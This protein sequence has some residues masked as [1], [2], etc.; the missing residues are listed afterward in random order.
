M[1]T[2]K[3]VLIIADVL[4]LALC[5]VQC[6]LSSKD[7]TKYF[8]LKDT[9]DMIVI[10]A[11]EADEITVVLEDGK[12]ILADD[13]FPANEDEIEG[14]LNAVES[15]RVLDKVGS[16]NN[17]A[18]LD[19]YEL[20]DLKKTTVTFSKDGKVIRTLNLGKEAVSDSQSYITVDNGKEIY[21]A[22]GNLPY[23]YGV[24]KND[25]RS[26]TVM[27]LKAGEITEVSIS[28]ED[29]TAWTLSRMGSGDD[30]VWNLSDSEVDVDEESAAAWFRNLAVI[31]TS[32]WYEEND[33]PYA[34]KIITA[35]FVAAFKTTT[36]DI[37]ALPKQEGVPQA[38]YGRTSNLPYAFAIGSDY[39]DLLKKNPSELGK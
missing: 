19:R 30:V 26:S 2:R 15:I 37:Y 5:I 25:I 33:V 38:Y 3:L 36:V 18:A 28:N 17:E 7:T 35:K 12:W 6:A 11:P 14:M 10:K 13:K 16:T 23:V 4:L 8:D 27:E 22:T 20:N 9:P 34:E 1:K 39:V 32:N 24:S 29:G 21:L 31:T